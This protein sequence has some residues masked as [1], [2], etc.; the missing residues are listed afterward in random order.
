MQRMVLATAL[1]YLSCIHLH[2]QLYD[3]GSYTLDITGPLMVITQKVTSLAFNLHDGLTRLDTELSKHRKTY[4]VYKLPSLLEYFS[5]ALAFPALMAGPVLF[6]KDYIDFIDGKNLLQKPPNKN[7]D[8]NSNSRTVV[9]EPSPIIVV[10]KKVALSMFFAAMFVTFIPLFTVK[11]VK[12]D[13]FLENTSLLYKFWY[14]G[15]SMHLVRFKYY[16][17]WLFADAICNNAGIGFVGYDENGNPNWDGFSNIHILKFEEETD[18]SCISDTLEAFNKLGLEDET[19]KAKAITIKFNTND[20]TVFTQSYSPNTKIFEVKSILEDVFGTTSDNMLL[21]QDENILDGDM[22]LKD[23]D[24]G[25]Y[26]ILELTLHSKN[27]DFT[28]SATN[29]YKEFTAVPDVLTVQVDDSDTEEGFRNVVVE[30]LN[31]AIKKPFLGGFVNQCSGV[32]YHHGYSQTGPPKPK[33]SPSRKNHRSTQTQSI[34]R[35]KAYDTGYAQATQMTNQDLW[36]PNI[37]DKILTCGHYETAEEKEKRL[38]IEE[39]VRIIQRYF[40]AWKMR[41]ALK[42]LSAEYKKRIQLEQELEE[43]YLK[44]DEDRKRQELIGK[45]F[46]RTKEDFIMLYAMVDR[47]KKCE[48]K[49]ICNTYSG[50]AKITAFYMLLDREVDMLRAIE[51]HRQQIKKEMKIKKDYDFFKAISAEIEWDY[52][53]VDWTCNR[54]QLHIEMDTLETQQ[55]RKYYKIFLSLS[56]EEHDLEDK[57]QAL[58][59]LKLLLRDHVCQVSTELISLIDRA[60][61]LLVRGIKDKYQ[62]ILMKRIKG[63]FIKHVK[64][65]ECS[66]GVTNRISRMKE[67]QMHSHLYPCIRCNKLKMHSEFPISSTVSKFNVCLT[68]SWDDRTIDPWIEIAPY[69]FILRLIRHEEKMK[70]SESSIA[71]I[72][73]PKDIYYIVAQIWHGHSAVTEINDIY[74]LRLCRW[75]KDKEWAPWNCILLTKEEAKIHYQIQKLEDVYDFHFLYRI[76]NKHE[77]AKN[78][79]KKALNLEKYFQDIGEEDTRWNEIKDFKEFVALSTNLRDSILAWNIGTNR[80]LRI[81]VFER[82]KNYGTVLTYALSVVWHGFYPGYY[83]TFA[84]AALL[85]FAARN[86]RRAFRH[87][88]TYSSES[89]FIYDCITFMV[90]RFCMAYITFTFVLLEFWPSIKLYLH[91]YLCLHILALLALTLVPRMMSKVVPGA[92]KSYSITNGSVAQALKQASPITNSVSNHHD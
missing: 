28:I 5:Y 35:S 54:K 67:K 20:E 75:F 2:R 47:W 83:L 43:Y 66:H 29:A 38:G 15:V 21:K 55:A 40:R 78:H 24:V 58:L 69:R 42:K 76:F 37:T 46:P 30:M 16:F 10:L 84:G 74:K 34:V 81:I 11:S 4:A 3:Y 36:I 17:A 48:I 44:V 64:M 63:L 52:D 61:E 87:H 8:S 72:L 18:S 88:F 60:C 45:V 1:I 89:K 31:L 7:V 41:K 71:F 57:L 91:M 13:D 70:Q 86:M 50:P 25:Q 59:N 79:F 26:N 39:K 23:F 90:T 33:V 56:D 51:S 9:L 73:Q 77:L 62:D 6:Y 68:C 19:Q 49:H 12:D 53:H 27:L 80:W 82:V 32:E 65:P 92:S 14:L 85:T 22:V